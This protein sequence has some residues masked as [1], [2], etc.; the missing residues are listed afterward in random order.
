[1]PGSIERAGLEAAQTLQEEGRLI[2]CVVRPGAA[3]MGLFS[4]LHW[5]VAIG[6]VAAIVLAIVR[7]VWRR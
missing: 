3:L 1:M 4:M 5:L 2:C 6:L 7:S